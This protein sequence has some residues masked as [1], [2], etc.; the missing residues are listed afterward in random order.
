MN[1]LKTNF[2][3]K[4][5]KNPMVTSSGCFGFGLEYKDYFDPNVLGGIVVKGI[6]M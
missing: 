5:F 6:T 4:E 2:L 1:R 3:G